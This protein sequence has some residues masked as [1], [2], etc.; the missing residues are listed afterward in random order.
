MRRVEVEPVA[1]ERFKSTGV[2]IHHPTSSPDTLFA[3]GGPASMVVAELTSDGVIG[4]RQPASSCCSSAAAVYRCAATTATGRS[5][6]RVR[7]W[8]SIRPRSMRRGRSPQRRWRSCK[9]TP[10][11]R[12]LRSSRSDRLAADEITLPPRSTPRTP[13]NRREQTTMAGQ[14]IA[15]I[16][17][18]LDGFVAGPHDG[19]GRRLGD[20][21]EP[22]H[23]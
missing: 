9:T 22:I 11:V 15:E 23:N 6:R 8:C 10:A 20:G 16:S 14:V 13:S 19:L 18:S 21:G 5:C 17:M 7:Q 3:V 2:T 4:R 1:I 12:H